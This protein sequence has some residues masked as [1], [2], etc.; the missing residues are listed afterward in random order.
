MLA[1]DEDD[2]A[3]TAS[4]TARRSTSRHKR[5]AAPCNGAITPAPGL[6]PDADLV[7]KLHS[8]GAVAL[9]RFSLSFLKLP[10]MSSPASTA[11]NFLRSLP[12]L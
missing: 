7:D 5:F 1:G 8:A 9:G 10:S 11:T 6:D 4:I 3:A 2:I 12:R